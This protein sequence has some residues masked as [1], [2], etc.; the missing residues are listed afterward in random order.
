LLC[1]LVLAAVLPF[2]SRA[3]YMDEPQYLH[4]ARSAVEHDWRFPQDTSWVF[5]GKRYANLSGQTHLPVVEYYLALLLRLFGGFSEVRFR[6]LFAVFPL[7]AVCSFY[8]LARRF[9][10]SPLAVSCLFAASPA[11]FVLSPTLMMDIPMLAF[12]LT[13]LATYFD[14][15]LWLA[16]LS[17]ILAAGTG[18]TALV[19]IGCLLI[20]AIAARRPARE[21]IAIAMAPAAI[22]IW[23][24]VLRHHFGESPTVELVGYYTSHWSWSRTLLPMFAFLGGVSLAPGVS[25]ILVETTRRRL[26]AVFSVGAAIALTFVTNWPSVEYRIWFAILAA[27]GIGLLAVFVSKAARACG[28]LAIWLPASL[29]F[30][31][32]FAEMIS[33]RYILLCLPPLFLVVFD[34]VRNRAATY[35]VIASLVVSVSLAVGDF[36]FVAR[37]PEFVAETVVPLERLGFRVWN[38]AESGLRFYLQANGVETLETADIRPKAGDLVVRQASFSYSLS[39]QLAPLLIP[40]RRFDVLDA[41]P[42]RTFSREAGAGFH[43]S[44]FGMVPYAISRAPLDRIE[45]AEVSPLVRSL[46]QK[47][48]EDFSSVPVWYPGGVLLKQVEEEMRFSIRMPG[49]SR[50]DY[51]LEGRGS[52]AIAEDEIVLTK[53]DTGPIVWKNFRIV[54]GAWRKE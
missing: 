54:P 2:A 23:L 10:A 12:L 45:I 36:R 1:A 21:W 42:V 51:E 24:L 47:V 41:Y 49:D 33:A 30:L 53:Q 28:C 22:G 46:T 38:A 7:L 39:E 5:F 3:V 6:V 18:Y 9:T 40:I 34:R 52:V 37:Y 25:L 48:P 20:W 11:F 35:A 16:S 8:R 15:R 13:G 19:P 26:I 44:H 32:V 31:L 43:D 4:I 27:S 50:V 14:G 17:L 29:A